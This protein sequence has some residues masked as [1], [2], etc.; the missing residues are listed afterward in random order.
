VL[1]VGGALACSDVAPMPE[2]GAYAAEYFDPYSIDSMKQAIVNLSSNPD[3]RKELRQLGLK[4]V[5]ELSWDRCGQTIW[6]AAMQAQQAF[7]NRKGRNR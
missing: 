3:R 1:G 5:A 6:Q 7:Q 2:L 4:R